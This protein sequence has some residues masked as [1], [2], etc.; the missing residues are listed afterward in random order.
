MIP[1]IGALGKPAMGSIYDTV[2]TPDTN[3]QETGPAQ[4]EDCLHKTATD[5]PFCTHP[6]VIADDRLQDRL[7]MINNRPVIKIN[8]ETGW[9]KYFRRGKEHEHG[10]D[11][12]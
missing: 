12:E 9:C 5:E 2:G 1:G 3:Y 4:C 7:V 8:M 11:H 6:K 10:E